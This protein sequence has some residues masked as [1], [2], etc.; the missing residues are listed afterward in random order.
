ML[1]TT[2][3]EKLTQPPPADEYFDTSHLKADLK[4][5]F[6]RGSAITAFGQAARFVVQ[7]G[8]TVVLGRLLS[9]KDYG[10]V[11]MVTA[12]TGFMMIFKD[13]GLS[14]AAVQ[15]A[16]TNHQQISTLF[17]INVAISTVAMF[18]TATL[19]RLLSHGSTTNR[20]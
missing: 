2:E 12:V 17:W 13:L 14:T 4:G 1:E 5:R 15:K 19:W 7:A 18:V 11:A 3:N 10:L 9:P 16:Q 8:S 6:V 20:D